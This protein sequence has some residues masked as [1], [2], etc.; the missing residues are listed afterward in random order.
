MGFSPIF[1]TSNTVTR[2]TER[3]DSHRG[4][5]VQV[6]RKLL[7]FGG[8]SLDSA[9]GAVHWRGRTLELSVPERELLGVLM[10]R[11]GQIV[12]R[13]RL[14]LTVGRGDQIDTLVATL[15]GNLKAAGV[16]ALPRQVDGLGY[17]LWRS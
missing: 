15:R 4:Q 14:A 2:V 17:I 10:R 11:A 13:E 3:S 5:G 16:T 7:R 6:E 8:L 9:T 12:S 1:D